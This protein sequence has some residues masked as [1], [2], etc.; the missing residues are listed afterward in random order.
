MT[1]DQFTGKRTA[2]AM[3]TAPLDAGLSCIAGEEP[4]DRN[5]DSDANKT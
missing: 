5:T 3:P 1:H 4:G 2:A